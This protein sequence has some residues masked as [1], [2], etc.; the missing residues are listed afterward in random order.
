MDDYNTSSIKHDNSSLLL[1]ERNGIFTKVTCPFQVICIQSINEL[2]DG[3]V[4]IVSE[5]FGT[6]DDNILFVIEGNPYTHTY[7]LLF[8]GLF[9]YQDYKYPNSDL[10]F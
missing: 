9:P 8:H 10:P 3:N 5:V 2:T 4:Y 7:F 6:P 1:I